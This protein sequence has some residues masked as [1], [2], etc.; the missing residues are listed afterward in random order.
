MCHH[1]A[2]TFLCPRQPGALVLS[3]T[4]CAT[5]WQRGRTAQ[6]DS[7][8]WL[9][10]GCPLGAQHAGV[11]VAPTPVPTPGQ[12]CVRCGRADLRLIAVSGLCVSC[13]N[14]EREV[15]RGRDRRGHAP[16]TVTRVVPITVLVDG[17]SVERPAASLVEVALW[18]ASRAPG[19]ILGRPVPLAPGVQ[20]GLWP[21]LSARLPGRRRG[22]A[23]A[24]G[25]PPLSPGLY[26]PI[27]LTAPRA[28][29][30]A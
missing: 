11:A 4:A 12:W 2:E 15:R 26:L 19:A 25:E 7:A 30:H 24:R 10:R 23:P 9:C 1:S 22:G 6:C 29:A 8:A 5:L 27:S 28:A 21:G 16:A 20:P 13:Y 18:A 14:R 3:P 17:R